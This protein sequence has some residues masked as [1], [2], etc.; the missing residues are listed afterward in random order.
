[1]K[2][3]EP[4]NGVWDSTRSILV[5]AV[6]DGSN[7]RFAAVVLLGMVIDLLLFQLL[8]TLGINLELWQ[9]TR[10]F[11]GAILSFAL[12]AYGGISELKQSSIR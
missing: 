11:G 2:R 6:I 5:N 4:K 10:F 9:I 3:A 1:M 12:N 7:L 8:F